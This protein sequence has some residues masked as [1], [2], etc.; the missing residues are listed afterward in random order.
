MS[1]PRSISRP[2]QRSVEAGADGEKGEKGSSKGEGWMAAAARRARA[3]EGCDEV[4]VEGTAKRWA[5]IARPGRS[6]QFGISTGYV[7]EAA[8]RGT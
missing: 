7:H 2:R 8:R 3:G 5:T 4:E 6:D 1:A